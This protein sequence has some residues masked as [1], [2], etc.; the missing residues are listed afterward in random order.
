MGEF[1]FSLQSFKKCNICIFEL[2][3]VAL[4]SPNAPEQDFITWSVSVEKPTKRAPLFVEMI[5]EGFA[6]DQEPPRHLH[7]HSG[8][9]LPGDVSVQSC[10]GQPPHSPDAR[11]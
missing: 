10:D 8:L 4:S 2:L 1:D 7:Q 9:H 11:G 3:K 5:L 6:E